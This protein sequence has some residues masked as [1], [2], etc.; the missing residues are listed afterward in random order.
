M[1]AQVRAVFSFSETKKNPLSAPLKEPLLYVQ[2]F[3]VF[4]GP[5]D[6]TKMYKLR[7]KQYLGSD[8][9]SHR[10]GGVIPI[11]AVTHAVELI[12]IYGHR[13]NREAAAN[14]S[15]EMYSEFYLNNYSDKEWYHTISQEYL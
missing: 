1:V 13:H 12:P 4:D 6:I 14:V 8:G 3:E 5:D 10:A 2:F 9:Q 7:R 15:L 11:T